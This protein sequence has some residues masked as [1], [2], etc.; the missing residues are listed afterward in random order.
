MSCFMVPKNNVTILESNL[1]DADSSYEQWSTGSYGLG[2]EVQHGEDIFRSLEDANTAEPIS[3]TLTLSWKYLKKA[4]KWA[5]F[6]D[7]NST[8]TTNL[9]KIEYVVESR[10]IDYIG[11][12]NLKADNVKVELFNIN[13]DVT[14]ATPLSIAE[15]KTVFRDTYSH[16]SY[17][18]AIGEYKKIVLMDLFP[19][20]NTKMR[21]T[22]SAS[23]GFVSVGNIVY[24]KKYNLGMTLA[25]TSL[26]MDIGNLFDID[27]DS[28]TGVIKQV[29]I[30]PRKDLTIP[31]LIETKDWERVTNKLTELMGQSCLY[32][33]VSQI[34]G[35]RPNVAIFGFYKNI[36]TPIGAEYTQYELVIKGVV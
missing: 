34:K 15:E 29:P 36:R 1:L 23:S 4:N 31:I 30:L 21:I 2:V 28:E 33:A 35:V 27:I 9:L 25:N 7:K 11:F 14:I 13:D 8:L 24:G 3:E 32:V 10:Y 5:A 17:I 18:T 19:Y 22:I 26:T 6:D 20:Y 16:S 12:F